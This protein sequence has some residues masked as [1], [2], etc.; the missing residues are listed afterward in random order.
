MGAPRLL[1]R[2]SRIIQNLR[3]TSAGEK[4][5]PLTDR[6]LRRHIGE[7]KQAHGLRPG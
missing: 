1:H 7:T 3:R 4:A 5:P 2:I 6:K